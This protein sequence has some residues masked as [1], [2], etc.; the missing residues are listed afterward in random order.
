MRKMGD[1]C[2]TFQMDKNGMYVCNVELEKL[3]ASSHRGA[4]QGAMLYPNLFLIAAADHMYVVSIIQASQDAVRHSEFYKRI[5][6][7]LMVDF[8]SQYFKATHIVRP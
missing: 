1:I 7:C 6:C 5:L 3:L 8:Y 2:F 4:L